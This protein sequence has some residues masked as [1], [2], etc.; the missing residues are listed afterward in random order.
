MYRVDLGKIDENKIHEFGYKNKDRDIEKVVLAVN[1]NTVQLSYEDNSDMSI[2]Y[3][4]D[5][6]HMIKALQM[7]YDKANK[8]F[9]NQD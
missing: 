6:P 3:V 8:N 5:I 4:E 9:D 7:A 1:S 2:V